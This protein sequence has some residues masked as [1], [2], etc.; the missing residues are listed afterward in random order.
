[1]NEVSGSLKQKYLSPYENN[2]KTAT[3]ILFGANARPMICL[4]VQPLTKNREPISVHFLVD[5][6]SPISYLS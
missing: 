3:G 6:G 4:P 2:T 1:M 5:T